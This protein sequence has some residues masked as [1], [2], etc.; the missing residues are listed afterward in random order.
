MGVKKRALALSRIS[1]V[2][3]CSAFEGRE[4]EM[5]EGE[6][7]GEGA[8]EHDRRGDPMRSSS[9]FS[10]LKALLFVKVVTSVSKSTKH[11]SCSHSSFLFLLSI[12][13]IGSTVSAIMPFLHGG[14]FISL[15]LLLDTLTP[16]YQSS[17][18]QFH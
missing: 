13:E 5:G 16:H 12:L 7:R 17:E 9:V 3:F 11:R 2:A 18:Y 15:L 4:R 6:G 10:K 8:L 14:E 1:S